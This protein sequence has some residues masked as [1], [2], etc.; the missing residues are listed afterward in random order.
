MMRRVLGMAHAADL[1]G[2]PNP[3]QRAVAES[4]AL[5]IG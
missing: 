2:I 5:N 4:M 3:K 1:G